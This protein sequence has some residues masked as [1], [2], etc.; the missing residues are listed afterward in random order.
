MN[1]CLCTYFSVPLI[2]VYNV[3]QN[4]R[5]NSAS[6]DH[7]TNAQSNSAAASIVGLNE[8]SL[9]N[10]ILRRHPQETAVDRLRREYIRTSQDLTVKILKDFLAKKLS[11]SPPSHFQVSSTRLNCVDSHDV[12]DTANS[13]PTQSICLLDSHNSW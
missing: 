13:T 8:S 11:Y 7:S 12:F 5:R 10:F 1:D 3:L 2:Y 4:K 9:I 6:T